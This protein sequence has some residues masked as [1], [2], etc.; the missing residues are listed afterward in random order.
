MAWI[1]GAIWSLA[2]DLHPCQSL[3]KEWRAD[4]VFTAM[5]RERI[6]D[7]KISKLYRWIVPASKCIPTAWARQK[8][9][10]QSIGK[11]RGGWTTKLHL[12]AADARTAVILFAFSRTGTQRSAWTNSL[13]DFA[14]NRRQT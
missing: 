5:Q 9:G 12:V 10:S 4:R 8:N 1:A 6:I 13:G 7:V 14:Y 11:S 2:Y 3:G